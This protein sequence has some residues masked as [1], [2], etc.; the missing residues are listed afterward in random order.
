VCVARLH[1]TA[2]AARPP[3]KVRGAGWAASSTGMPL[4]RAPAASTGCGCNTLQRPRCL[5][6]LS[7]PLPPRHV[8][9]DLLVL[10]FHFKAIHTF[11]EWENAPWE[12]RHTTRPP[13]VYR[14]ALAAGLTGEGGRRTHS[15]CAC[16]LLRRGFACGFR[17]PAARDAGPRGWWGAEGSRPVRTTPQQDN[18]SSIPVP[19]HRTRHCGVG[20]QGSCPGLEGQRGCGI[21]VLRQ[22]WGTNGGAGV[23]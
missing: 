5:P 15:A 17:P 1:K 16:A 3:P 23:T 22:V 9:T 10:G 19:V 13:S 11:V 8:L 2:S 18:T 14:Q 4:P 7:L 21:R 20:R 6:R 12:P